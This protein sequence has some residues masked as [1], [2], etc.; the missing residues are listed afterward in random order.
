MPR[1]VQDGVTNMETPRKDTLMARKTPL[2]TP[3]DVRH[4]R[5]AAQEAREPTTSPKTV[6]VVPPF[7]P[8]DVVIRR[9]WRMG[10]AET[11]EYV[12][13]ADLGCVDLQLGVVHTRTSTFRNPVVYPGHYALV[14]T[15]SVV[16]E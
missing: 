2:D 6:G 11:T 10:A 5:E 14:R 3:Q 15:H 8:G 13:T 1:A 16:N 12:I 4:A 7:V 9:S